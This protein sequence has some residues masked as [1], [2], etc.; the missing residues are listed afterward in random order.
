[1]DSLKV[2]M[3]A[4][5]TLCGT[6][7]KCFHNSEITHF[8]LSQAAFGTPAG[9]NAKGI[10]SLFKAKPQM[11]IPWLKGVT[12]GLSA[13][14]SVSL[15]GLLPLALHCCS[16]L[17]PAGLTLSKAWPI[18]AISPT[19]ISTKAVWSQR[20]L[21]LKLA[22]EPSDRGSSLPQ[23]GDTLSRP[24][25]IPSIKPTIT[26]GRQQREMDRHHW[27]TWIQLY[28][29]FEHPKFPQILK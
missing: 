29:K 5:D 17:L 14:L 11:Q 2:Q 27:N 18:G 13:S 12:C 22:L 20:D 24:Q 3:K 9:T 21:I 8:D 23:L 4:E 10:P 1:M 28:L 25:R 26:R 15:P 7:T 16:F 19:V 6:R